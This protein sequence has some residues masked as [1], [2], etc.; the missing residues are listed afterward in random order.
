MIQ[1]TIFTEEGN[2]GG[3]YLFQVPI[4]SR[5]HFTCVP[6][7]LLSYADFEAIGKDLAAKKRSGVVHGYNWKVTNGLE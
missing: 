7:D 1:I 3:A 6:K 5:L 4:E 2:V